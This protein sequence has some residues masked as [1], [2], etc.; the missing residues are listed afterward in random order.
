MDASIGGKNGV[1]FEGYKNMVGIIRQPD[2]VICDPEMLRTL[3]PA[4]YRMGFAEVIKYG[5]IL[6]PDLFE[7][8]EK[9][10]RAALEHD[11]HHYGGDNCRMCRSANVILSPVMRMNQERGKN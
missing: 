10:H 11:P 4:E 8:L 1:N 3:E 7:F 6:N 2:F 5:A 9:N